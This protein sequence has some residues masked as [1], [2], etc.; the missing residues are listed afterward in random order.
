MQTKSYGIDPAKI[1]RAEAYVQEHAFDYLAVAI[2]D[3]D[4]MREA[5]QKIGSDSKHQDKHI[6]TLHRLAHDMKG[7]AET[8]G[9]P[10]LTEIAGM[11]ANFTKKILRPEPK[12]ME[13]ILAHID[14]LQLCLSRKIF[15]SDHPEAISLKENLSRALGKV[16]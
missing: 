7:Q 5:W 16:Q 12:Q 3:I 2:D 10:V 15:D 11:L 4:A 8:F 9:Q 13:L 1:A 14:S 6:L